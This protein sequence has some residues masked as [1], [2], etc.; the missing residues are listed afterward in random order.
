MFNNEFLKPRLA[1]KTSIPVP[2]E[3]IIVV[4]GT[5]LSRYL[6]MNEKWQIVLVGHIPLGEISEFFLSF[7]VQRI[8]NF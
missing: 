1:K 3:L 7:K 4:S 6:L 2:I 5:L 8:S